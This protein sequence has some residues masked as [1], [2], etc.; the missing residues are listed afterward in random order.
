MLK[1]GCHVEAL[2][3]IV[4]WALAIGLDYIFDNPDFKI[5]PNTF[6]GNIVVSYVIIFLATAGTIAVCKIVGKMPLVSYY[7]RYSIIPLC[8]HHLVYRPLLIVLKLLPFSFVE[9]D[10]S[11]RI[12]TTIVTILLMWA[13]IPLCL[14]YIPYFCGQKNIIE[15]TPYADKMQIRN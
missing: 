2:W 8:L 10:L 3:A 13:M 14:K 7:G 9:D 6:T 12:L 4:L 15:T 11:L 5:H 1:R